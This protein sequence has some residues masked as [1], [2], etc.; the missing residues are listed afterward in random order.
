VLVAGGLTDQRLVR[1]ASRRLYGE[2][3][4]SGVRIFEYRPAMTH[5]KTLIVDDTWAVVGT[6]NIDNRSFEHNDEINV[7]LRGAAI[8]GTI[9]AE[10]ERDLQSS[11][12]V[13]AT[14]WHARPRLERLLG[15]VCWLLE[16]QQ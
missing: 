7:A 9:R 4:E 11:D 13:T 16:R 14:A 12:E 15:P 8:V 10:F 2:L 1:L 6:A 3:L 5:L